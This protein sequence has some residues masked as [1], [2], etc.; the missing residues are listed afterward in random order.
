M[1]NLAKTVSQATISAM[2]GLAF[3]FAAMVPASAITQ[4]SVKITKSFEMGSVGRLQAGA[5]VGAPRAFTS[6]CHTHASH[7]RGGGKAQVAM[8]ADLMKL[9]NRTNNRVNRSIRLRAEKVDVWKVNVRVGDCEDFVLT[10]RAQLI[11]LG[12]PA[13]SLRIGVGYTR[14]GVGHAVLVVRTSKG[15][16]V[17]D[18]RR[19]AILPWNKTGIDWLAISGA[20]PRNWN[21]V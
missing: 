17:L 8:T 13:S 6:F 15:D 16:F 19:R 1:K 3:V 7:C 10:K 14:P 11:K 4:R 12:V 18:N 2:L 21:R 9:L 20:N 5:S